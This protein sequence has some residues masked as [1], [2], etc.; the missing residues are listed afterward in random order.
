[1]KGVLF[2]FVL[3]L[4]KVALG[5]MGEVQLKRISTIEEAAAFIR[6]NPH[7]EGQVLQLYTATDTAASWQPLM[8]KLKG[9]VLTL[10]GYTYKVLSDT[11][12]FFSRASYIYLD[13]AKLST[14]QIDSLRKRI[15]QQYSEGV[16]FSQ[17]AAQYTMDDNPNGGDTGWFTEGTM[18][19]T[20]E[21][22][23][24]KH[25]VPEVFTVDVPRNKWYYVVKKTH[26]SGVSKRLTVLRVKATP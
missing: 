17:L 16:P 10:D 20:F 23:L 26:H 21:K 5:Q 19:E 11:T 18:V 6:A 2:F 22:A 7:L 9:Q 4:G 14:A 8:C 13:G 24:K 3:L 15:L 25:Q 1:M 12:A